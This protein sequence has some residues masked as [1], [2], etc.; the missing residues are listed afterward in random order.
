MINRLSSL[1]NS[2]RNSL[3]SVYYTAGFPEI[4]DTLSVAE[5]LEESGVDLLEIGI[6]FSDPIADGPTIQA[7]NDVALANG[8][9]ISLLFDQIKNLRKEVKIP[10]L[11]MGYFNPIYQFGV[12][13]FCQYCQSVG[14]DGL[15]IPDMPLWEYETRWK[16][17]LEK[18]GLF[19]IF[20]I[21]PQT[22]EVRILT[23]DGLSSSFIYMV[24]SASVTGSKNS[25][26]G[27]QIGY[28]NRI[29]EMGLKSP[30]LIGFGIS[31]RDSFENASKFSRGAIIGSAFIE[32]L[33]KLDTKNL[34]ERYLPVKQFIK[35]IKE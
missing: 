34:T 32:V 26:S 33:K 27:D 1:F 3:L 23:I 13:K 17:I 35:S 28:F 21:T 9:N 16:I 31:N 2:G 15:I 24:S 19:N 20:L 4:T 18:Y 10:V 29:K 14:I 5:A 11:L 7:S 30:T 22:P 6:P 8:M 25:I 12:E